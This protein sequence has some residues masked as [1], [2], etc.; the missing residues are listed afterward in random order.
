MQKISPLPSSHQMYQAG[1]TIKTG[2]RSSF[3]SGGEQR[4]VGR[5]PFLSNL[6]KTPK[7]Q[8]GFVHIF[9]LKKSDF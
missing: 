5:R 2:Q 4:D 7:G 9:M 8:L 3:S 1:F 6:V